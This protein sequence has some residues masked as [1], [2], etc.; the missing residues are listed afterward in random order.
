M[1]ILFPVKFLQ[2]K[3][4]EKK[5]AIIVRARLVGISEIQFKYILKS[6]ILTGEPFNACLK[7]QSIST[8]WR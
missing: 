5:T 6:W 7:S 4:F 3:I 1:L 2:S 8:F